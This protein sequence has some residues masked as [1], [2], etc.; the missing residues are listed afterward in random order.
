M[1]C[2]GLV[3]EGANGAAIQAPG[4][5]QAGLV[6]VPSASSN[7]FANLGL[8]RWRLKRIGWGGKGLLGAHCWFGRLG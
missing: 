8:G 7:R 3:H 5:R 2:E 6:F 4:A 1:A